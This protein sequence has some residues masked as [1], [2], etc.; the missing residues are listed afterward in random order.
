MREATK[1]EREKADRELKQEAERVKRKTE[2]S[3]EG[4]CCNIS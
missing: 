3:G 4:E 1:K 2:R